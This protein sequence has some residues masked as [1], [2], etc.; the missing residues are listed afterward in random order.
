MLIIAGKRL[1]EKGETEKANSQFKI[2][3]KV[4]DA[5]AEDFVEEK[6]FKATVYE[7]T[8]EQRKEIEELLAQSPQE[9]SGF[10][11]TP[12]IKAFPALRGGIS[13]AYEN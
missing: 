7:Y 6:W 2:A 12:K 3:Q 9:A 11:G 4:I 8:S 1:K 10:S 13:F 5:F